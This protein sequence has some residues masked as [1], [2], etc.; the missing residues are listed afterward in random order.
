MSDIYEAE[1]RIDEEPNFL[2]Q[3]TYDDMSTFEIRA[4]YYNISFMDSIFL[5]NNENIHFHDNLIVRVPN[6]HDFSA[7]DL[8]TQF[9][10][11]KTIVK[12]EIINKEIGE[13]EYLQ[14]GYWDT[15]YTIRSVEAMDNTIGEYEIILCHRVG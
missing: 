14:E 6:T 3:I 7:V 12:V 2:F 5:R 10:S 11:T 9:H 4:D 1:G 15:L 8:L 13:S